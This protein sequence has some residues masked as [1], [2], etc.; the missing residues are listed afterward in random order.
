M[1]FFVCAHF[2]CFHFIYRRNTQYWSNVFADPSGSI[3]KSN[4]DGSG[5]STVIDGTLDVP[6]KKCLLHI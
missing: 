3:F 5:F 6:G 4:L 2:F 1:T